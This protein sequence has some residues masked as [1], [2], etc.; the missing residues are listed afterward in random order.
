LVGTRT[1]RRLAPNID[2]GGNVHLNVLEPGARAGNHFHREMEEFFVNPGPGSLLMHVRHPGSGAVEVIEMLPASRSEIRAYRAKL[3]VPHI[4]ENPG[5][6]RI[7]LIIIVDRDNPE[8]I[9]P[10]EVYLDAG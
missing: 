7:A 8:D 1:D 6:H 9:H 10:A 4:V 2:H 3:G 5:P